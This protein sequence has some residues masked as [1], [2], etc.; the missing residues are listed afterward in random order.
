VT[1]RHRRDDCV[2]VDATQ[3][4]ADVEPLPH[5]RSM[6]RDAPRRRD[7]VADVVRQVERI[8]LDRRQRDEVV[9]E[10][11]EVAAASFQLALARRLG[12]EFVRGAGIMRARC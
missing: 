3:Q 11:L 7:G 6:A 1:L 4:L 12:V 10:V 9:P 5:A 8:E 2:G